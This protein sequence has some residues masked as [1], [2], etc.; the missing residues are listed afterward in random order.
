EL[1]DRVR[2]T[3]LGAYAHQDLPFEKL[4]EELRPVR[5]LARPPLFQ[6]MFVVQNATSGALSL[7]GLELTVLPVELGIAKFDLTLALREEQGRL[8]GLL[9]YNRDLFDA[10]T[11]AR[12]T[13]HFATLLEAAVAAPDLPVAELPLL[14]AGER[15]QALREWNDRAEGYP[16]L[17]L[18]HELIAA[19]AAERP[20][21]PAVGFGRERLSYGELE[22]RGARIARHLRTRGAGPDRLVGIAVERSFAMVAALLGIWKAGAAY[23][24]LDATLPAERLAFMLADAGVGVVLT[25]ASLRPA[26]PD[27]TGITL[28]VEDLWNDE[29]AGLVGGIGDIGPVPLSDFPELLDRAAYV[30][31]TSGST[32][33]P[34]GVVVSHRALGNRLRFAQAVELAPGDSF[35]QK[36]TTSFDA[37]IAEIWSPLLAGGTTVLARPGGEREPAHLIAL[38][39]EW[40]IAHM[41]FTMAMLA[42]LLEEQS[43]AGCDSLRTVMVGGEA[44]PPDLPARFHA[45]S[46]ADIFNRYGP[47]ETTISI[48]SWRCERGWEGRTVPIGRPMARTEVYVLD[49]ALQPLPM[50]V[51]GELCIGGVGLARGYLNRP[52]GTAEKFVPQPF[53]S[54]PGAR[55][56]RSGDLVRFRPDGAIEFV[57]RTDSQVKIRGFRVELG[58]I[59]A[60]LAQ[61][62]GLDQVAVVDR[63]D[64]GGGSRRLVAYF[65]PRPTRPEPEPAARELQQFLA[66]LLPG[67]MVPAAFVRLAA[68]PLTPTGKTDR[69]VLPEPDLDDRPEEGWEAP[70]TPVEE[71]L[72]GIWAELLAVS[73]VGRNESFFALGGHSLLATRLVSR[74]REALGVE[75]PLKAIFEAP[76]LAGLAALVAAARRDRQA[77]GGAAGPAAPPLRPVPRSRDLPLSFAQERLWFLE[78][79][80]PGSAAYNLPAAVRFTGRLAVPALTG[81]LAGVVARH[82]VLRTRFITV[83][84]RPVQAVNPVRDWP[85]PAVDLAALPAVARE[86][87]ARRLARADARRP[88]D[89]ERGPL[90]RAALLRLRRQEPEEHVLLLGFHHIVTDGWS[91]GV[92][93]R[94]LGA[95]YS[96]EGCPAPLPPLPVQY[97]D[98]A[99]WQREWLAGEVL[100]AELSWWRERLAGAPA[101]LDLPTD[102]PRPAVQGFRGGSLPFRLPAAVTASLERLCRRQG[103]TPFMALLAGFATLLRRW[104]G[105][106]D[107]VV[108]SPV[109]NRT[110]RETEGLIGF[111]V[112]SLALRADLAGEPAFAELLGRVREQA[113]G[114]YAH[115]DLPFEKLVEALA[116]E[117]SLAYAPLFQAFLVLQ[118][119][120]AGKLCLP[121]L[122]LAPLAGETGTAKFDLTLALGA[123]PA[124]ELAGVWE[125]DRDLF[126]PATVARLGDQLARL[127]AA[128]VARPESRIGDL[129]LF[130]PG[131]GQMLREWGQ[132]DTVFEGTPEICLHEL[133]AARAVRHPEAE[134]LIAGEE[135][136]TYGELA[137]RAGRLAHLLWERGVGPEER[138]GVCLGRS[139]GLVVALL[140]VL[141]AGGA[142]VPLD[143][144]YPKERL[145]LMLADSGAR[146]VLTEAGL[147]ERLPATGCPTLL[148]DAAGRPAGEP[149]VG[150]AGA[151]RGAQKP[152][153]GNLA[154]LIYTSGSTGR[155]KGVAIAHRSAVALALWGRQTF[156]DEELSGVLAATSVSFDLSVFEL[157][158][159]LAWGGRVILA[160]NALALAGLPAAGEVRLV[161]TVPSAMAE[162][163]HLGAVP[164]GVRTVN[165][166]GEPLK[167]PLVAALHGL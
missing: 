32:G 42:T 21:A 103:V 96:V 1:V 79:L 16:R 147:R 159:P 2:Q 4:V 80:D 49:R 141:E 64:P 70:R 108:G 29:P 58:E 6:V 52:E 136:L 86:G 31:Y 150:L 7:P 62:P 24:P 69:R 129:P 26:L 59:E 92:F 38:I 157:F 40:R 83:E 39:R 14:T 102:R 115:Q 10:P 48:T 156:G 119:T 50:G 126:D 43:L 132:G 37:S 166:A 131:E 135:R 107:L 130:S 22:A 41:S 124:G 133:F 140:A 68:M 56:Y 88:F 117:R 105:Q 9:E 145:G 164:A 118:N 34:K 104:S 19:R 152:V 139:A 28:L 99:V 75:L 12:L 144:G 113:L 155:P 98:F 11:A 63:Q 3:A 128:V 137:K 162:L 100:A 61:H 27:F 46:E 30:I 23:L 158:V 85:L 165:L 146:L 74:L 122:E 142:Y 110:H 44:L 91:M 97:A 18:V 72:A 54:A 143:P 94:E 67:Y 57:G 106:D 151:S 111:F 73:R 149:G 134:A 114:A 60:A 163:V 87:E 95:L 101:V 81:A 71:L 55:L 160:D 33:Q 90:F 8:A 15:H 13:A 25:Q 65:V 20:A 36:T 116:P 167:R 84:G 82:E 121:D 153:P 35:V 77:E 76:T 161:N 45:Q 138:V 123:S 89:L 66:G 5:Q 120:P 51:A 47:T 109:A 93:V 17:G 127:L 112:N 78:Q 148:L 154:Y 53:A 125:Y